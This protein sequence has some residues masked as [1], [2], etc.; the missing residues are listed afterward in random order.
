MFWFHEN[1]KPGLK[2]Q[3]AL[4]SDSLFDIIDLII[5]LYTTANRAH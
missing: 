5:S 3:A 4:D 1:R 2:P